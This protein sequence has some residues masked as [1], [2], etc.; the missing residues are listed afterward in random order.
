MFEQIQAA[1]VAGN[2]SP[3]EKKKLEDQA[4][5]KGVQ[6]LFKVGYAYL[7]PHYAGSPGLVRARNSRSSPSSARHATAS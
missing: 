5:E 3:E 1:E 2:L 7:T 4:A 6:A